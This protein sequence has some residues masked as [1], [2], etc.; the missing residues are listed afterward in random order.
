MLGASLAA[1]LALPLGLSAGGTAI[2]MTLA[3][4]ASDIA[5][6]AALRIALPQANLALALTM[7]IGVTFP[8]NLLLGIPLY[9]GIAGVLR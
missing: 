1:A 2:L 6:P 7:S 4:S 5:V 9:I 8:F 3:A